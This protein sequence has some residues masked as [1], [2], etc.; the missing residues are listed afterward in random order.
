MKQ[1]TIGQ[2]LT[3]GF[4][5]VIALSIALGGFA[6]WRMLNAA[7]GAEF[8]D[9]AVVPQSNLAS[10]LASHSEATNLAARTYGFTG[11]D[12][13][14]EIAMSEAAQVQEHIAEAIQLAVE[15]PALSA[16]GA[17]AK[18]AEQDFSEYVRLLKLTQQNV[19]ALSNLRESL[20]T[21]A[22]EFVTSIDQFIAVQSDRLKNEISEGKPAEDLLE[23][24]QKVLLAR[25]ISNL[26]NRVRIGAF[27]A[28]ALRDDSFIAEVMPV[29]DEMDE[30]RQE[31]L[32]I[33]RLEADLEELAAVHRAAQ[34][35]QKAMQTL[36][37]N[38][39]NNAELMEERG[40]V[41]A[42]FGEMMAEL[43][44]ISM[45]RTAEYAE[46]SSA[47]L[48]TSSFSLIIGLVVMIIVGVASAY[49]IVRSLNKV[50]GMTAG[51]LSSG[52]LQ[53][54]AASGQVSSASQ[55]LAEGSSEQ[56]AS[57]EEISSSIEELSSMTKRNAENAQQGKI[58]ANEARSAAESGAE[59]MG[60]MQEAMNAIQQSSNDISKIIKTIDEIAF[61]TNIL[62]LNAAVEAAR[63]GEAGAGFAVVADEVR[64]L[65]QRSAVAARETADK[66]ADATQRSSQGVELSAQVSQGL[67]QIVEKAREVD[68]LVAEVASAS[69][70]QSEGLSQINGAVTQLDT[71]T[72]SNAAGAEETS[73]A[74]EEL[75]A[76]SE[77]LKQSAAHLASLVGL[78]SVES[79]RETKPRMSTPSFSPE[80][81]MF[82]AEKKVDRFEDSQADALE[83]SFRD[84]N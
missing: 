40:A 42:E 65:A 61:Q 77:E 83:L 60:R 62:A 19:T 24:A 11:E 45:Q 56:A 9:K 51:N 64:S 35:Y 73:S 16:L 2:R 39:A 28:Q 14:F 47:S 63:A 81:R 57:L 10:Q 25:E 58:T 20:D 50:L 46:S 32:A 33:T 38:F 6:A 31:L 29:F 8:L 74:A 84:H 36:E 7:E 43:T 49:L 55:T 78:S 44:A 69:A 72:Q 66:I 76:Q 18:E 48:Q 12:R 15:Q 5:L 23:R 71:V 13:E 82:K 54:A 21:S 4:S 80:P 30:H 75:N 53:I 70:E 34:A 1:K 3:A 52:A 67:T 27:K 17:A 79:P 26:G 41:G 37:V 68:R 22:A 59:E